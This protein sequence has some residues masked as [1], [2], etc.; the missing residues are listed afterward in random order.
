MNKRIN[1]EKERMN[2]ESSTG[3]IKGWINEYPTW[4]DRLKTTGWIKEW[5]NEYPTWMDRLKKALQ[6]E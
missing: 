3:W 5:I 2:K 4:T 1:D 6:D